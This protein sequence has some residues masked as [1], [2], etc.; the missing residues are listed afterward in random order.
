MLSLDTRQAAE[1][2]PFAIRLFIGKPYLLCVASDSVVAT[3]LSGLSSYDY[4]SA[5]ITPAMLVRGGLTWHLACPRPR[6][7]MSLEV[8]RFRSN[9]TQYRFTG[10]HRL[11]RI[12]TT[13]LSFHIKWA[14]GWDGAWRT[15]EGHLILLISLRGP[16]TKTTLG[17]IQKSCSGDD[18]PNF[19]MRV[20]QHGLWNHTLSH[21]IFVKCTLSLSSWWKTCCFSLQILPKCTL[22]E[23][24]CWKIARS[25]ENFQELLSS[26]TLSSQK[27]TL[28]IA[29]S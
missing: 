5:R 19:G 16:V 10:A 20:C 8:G 18:L 21:A 2:Y 6:T 25:D 22:Y 23:Q 7:T 12:V 4:I 24:N 3:L 26:K 15:S 29:F 14:D 28:S 11:Y 27:H 13:A 1:G 9:R 17:G